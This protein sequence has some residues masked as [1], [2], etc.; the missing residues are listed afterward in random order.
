MI[1]LVFIAC[2]LADPEACRERTLQFVDVTQMQCAMGAQPMLAQW[3]YENPKWKV[4]RW[5]CQH[6]GARNPTT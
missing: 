5:S 6:A 2:M 1:E 3:T 4:I